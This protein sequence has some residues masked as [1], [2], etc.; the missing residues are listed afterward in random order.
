MP[1]RPNDDGDGDAVGGD[2]GDD[3]DDGGGD[4]GDGGGDGGGDHLYMNSAQ[5]DA[6]WHNLWG[7][8]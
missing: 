8:R 7:Y 3:G 4:V 6:G 5:L 1:P 2:G